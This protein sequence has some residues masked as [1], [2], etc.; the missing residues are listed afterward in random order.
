MLDE[1]I[2]FAE[3]ANPPEGF[4]E[5]A[6]QFRASLERIA[7][8][9]DLVIVLDHLQQLEAATFSKWMIEHFIK[10]IAEGRVKRVRLV[11][12]SPKKGALDVE[13]LLSS[14]RPV[15]NADQRGL[16]SQGGLR[17]PVSPPLP[18]V[19]EIYDKVT[20]QLPL[21]RDKFATG[22][23]KAQVFATINK[24]CDAWYGAL[25]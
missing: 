17:R 14:I 12:V 1:S 10:P 2:P 19:V 6:A 7:Q 5:D 23:W 16:L 25:R 3:S 18:A 8:Q 9:R 22:P 21:L 20:G 11:L 4:I 24:L 15:A 13:A